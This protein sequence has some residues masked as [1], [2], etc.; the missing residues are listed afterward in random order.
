MMKYN[1]YWSK[2][3]NVTMIELYSLLKYILLY[4]ETNLVVQHE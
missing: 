1:W 4:L 2:Y 3:W